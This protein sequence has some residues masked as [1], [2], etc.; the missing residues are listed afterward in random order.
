MVSA[1]VEGEDGGAGGAST[2]SDFFRVVF[3]PAIAS[4]DG[5]RPVGRLTITRHSGSGSGVESGCVAILRTPV[6][7]SS[8]I[9]SGG[10]IVTSMTE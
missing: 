3:L 1:S 2:D 6:I 5:V 9:S 10:S 8:D 4:D 7:V